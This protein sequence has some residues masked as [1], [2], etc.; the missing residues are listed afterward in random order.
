M[1][2]AQIV[3]LALITVIFAVII[4][5]QKPALAVLLSVAF[6]L[7]VM[8]AVMG[9]IVTIIDVVEEMTKKAN[10]NYFF[11]STVLKILG[12][13]Y[14]TEMG[15]AICRDAGEQAIATKIELAARIVIAVMALPIMVAILETLLEI[16]PG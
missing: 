2:I 3:G 14:L 16:M 6:A 10:A 4:R 13:A 15:A 1:E 11:L 7:L 8:L 9:R 12:V 5:Q